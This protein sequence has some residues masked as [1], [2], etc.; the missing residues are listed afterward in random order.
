MP[1]RG[2]LSQHHAHTYTCGSR[3]LFPVF[4]S[5]LLGLCL[6]YLGQSNS[7][8]LFIILC[9]PLKQGGINP[10][11]CDLCRSYSGYIR[12]Q[13]QAYLY[14]TMPSIFY[15]S[16]SFSKPVQ[17][18]FIRLHFEQHSFSYNLPMSWIFVSALMVAQT[19]L[20]LDEMKLQPE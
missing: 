8:N 10:F 4:L 9:P 12:G 13:F 15:Q 6:H 3:S 11:V 16:A 20:Q 5:H 14:L 1:E 17:W 19:W 18:I 7:A 2:M